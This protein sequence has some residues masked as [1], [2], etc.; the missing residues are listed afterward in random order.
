MESEADVLAP[1]NDGPLIAR[2]GHGTPLLFARRSLRR[3]TNPS[4]SSR[5]IIYV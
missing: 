4:Q 2:S 5:C 3:Q 1:R